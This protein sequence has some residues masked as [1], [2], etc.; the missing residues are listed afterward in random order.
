M[1]FGLFGCDREEK[2]R[3]ESYVKND[4]HQVDDFKVLINVENKEQKRG[5]NLN[6]MNNYW[7]GL[8]CIMK[9]SLLHFTQLFFGG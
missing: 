2:V 3:S 7:R 8:T 1:G 5:V 4:S 6:F 9:V